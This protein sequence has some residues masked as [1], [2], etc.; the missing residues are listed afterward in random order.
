MPGIPWTDI[1]AIGE[2]HAGADGICSVRTQ[3][4]SI[5]P[6]T[7]GCAVYSKGVPLRKY[8]H[9]EF[10]TDLGNQYLREVKRDCPEI[11]ERPGSLGR[12]FAEY[13]KEDGTHAYTSRRRI[14]RA[15]TKVLGDH[16][17]IFHFEVPHRK[18]KLP[19][20]LQIINN[21]LV[22]TVDERNLKDF[23]TEQY[24]KVI[25]DATSKGRWDHDDDVA[26]TTTAI[27]PTA[28]SSSSPLLSLAPAPTSAHA[29]LTAVNHSP[30]KRK[31]ADNPSVSKHQKKE[32][33]EHDVDAIL[34]VQG[35]KHKQYQVL[36]SDGTKSW[37]PEGNL[38]CPAKLQEFLNKPAHKK[39]AKKAKK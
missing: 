23:F 26:A 6:V 33:E 15:A 34:N 5:A 4:G 17:F 11:V 20:V 12:V 38:N 9:Q 35:E 30:R 1:G 31:P 19:P 25:E 14:I 37:V 39:K 8:E 24:A 16:Q 32:E 2:E 13:E 36:W 29:K 27:T 10:R 21:N 3:E 18:G 28:A 22:V 7:F